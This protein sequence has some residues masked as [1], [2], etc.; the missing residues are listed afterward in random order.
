M[1]GG[2]VGIEGFSV[3]QGEGEIN[4]ELEI[5]KDSCIPTAVFQPG[6]EGV[7]YVIGIEFLRPEFVD[8]ESP[9]CVVY[10]ERLIVI[11]GEEVI[12]TVGEDVVGGVFGVDR[13]VFAGD[14]GLEGVGMALGVGALDLLA[15]DELLPS[16]PVVEVP[17]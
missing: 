16:C 8:E 3:G 12:N 1:R 14:D 6:H 17:V 9:V 5:M 13:D 10:V 4:L 2:G 11:G 7:V 15:H